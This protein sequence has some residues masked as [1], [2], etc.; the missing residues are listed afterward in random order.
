MGLTG[1]MATK[2]R[3]AIITLQQQYNIPQPQPQFVRTIILTSEEGKAIK[4]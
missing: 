3:K 4:E 2:T 1:I